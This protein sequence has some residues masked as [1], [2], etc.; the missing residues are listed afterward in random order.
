MRPKPLSGVRVLDLTRLL[1]GPVATLHLADMGADVVKIEDTEEG[2]YSRRMGRVREGMSDF[3][4]LVNRNKRALRL[5]LKKPQGREVF[6]RLARGAEVV[7]ESFRP[8][9]MARLGL[10]Y[11]ALA[12]VNPRLVYCSITGYGQSGP[13][14]DRAG[15]DIN[16]IGYA[17]IGD[18]IGTAEAPVVPNFQ[19]A[20]L[21]GGALTPAMGILA[22]LIDARSSGRGRHVDVAM[23]DAVFAHAILPVL[24]FLEHGRTPG[25]GTSMLDGGLP[26]YN[27][28]RTQDGRW[29]AV[30]AL[31]RKFWETLCDILGC[32]ELK[33]KH[34]VY[35]EE[36]KPVKE[37]LAAGFASRTQHEWSEVFARADC[38]VSPILPIDEA[39]ANEQFR[40]REMIAG[41]GG[42]T[43][44]ALPLK[45]SEFE[46]RIARP[47]PGRGEHTEEIL[48]EAGYRDAEIAA[49]RGDGVI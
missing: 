41:E 22:A 17:G 19:I 44:L 15:H 1:P 21:L 28:Y 12:A 32:P 10:G 47:A 42:L 43:Q 37:R 6:L 8:G 16:Y 20:D 35:G 5:D 49:L 45:F 48:R 11:D 26:C 3:F 30:G 40:A 36:A 33:E 34:I 31:E 2:D 46:F 14:A 25:R 24:G 29:M 39:L 9:V 23:A 27:V 4:R 18:Q 38:C 7:V 13:Y